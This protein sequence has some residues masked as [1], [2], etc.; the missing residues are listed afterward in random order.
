VP[1][2]SPNLDDLT[3]A[4]V[5]DALVR[6]IPTVAPEWT[7]HN[8]SDPGITLIQL[9]ASLAE[10]I[11]YRLN[12][13]PEKNYLEFLKLIGVKLRPAEAARTALA[14]ILTE[15]ETTE[16]FLMD[17]GARAKAKPPVAPG[18]PAPPPLVFETDSPLD[19][20]P[21]Q[22]AA[23][24]TTQS[25]DLR[26]L[27]VEANEPDA[28]VDAD[29]YVADL[30]SLVWDGKTPKLKDLPTQPLRL[31]AAGT[32]VDH[33]SLWLGLAFNPNR[34]TG[35]LASRVT[36]TVQM[37]DDEQ[38]ASTAQFTCGEAV[39]ELADPGNPDAPQV[40]YSYY[41]PRQPGEAK[42]SWRPLVSLSDTTD[43]WTR[44][45]QARFDIPLA[46]GAVPDDEWQDVRQPVVKTLKDL[47]AE[48]GSATA[49]KPPP[50]PIPHPLVGAIKAPV[51]NTPAAVPISGWIQVRFPG[52]VPQFSVR[53]VSFNVAPAT[54]A[55]TVEQELVCRGSGRP[56]QACTLAFG[57]VLPDTLSL[58]VED[59]VDGLLHDWTPAT[60][61]D[62]AAPDARVYTL[63][64]EAGQITFGDG[65][66]GLP[67]PVRMRVVAR[68]YRHGGG[69]GGDVDVGAVNIP[70]GLDSHVQAVVNVVA[71][72]GGKDA[73]LLE[74]AKLRAPTELATF[75]RAV[76]DA[77]FV[78]FALR[79]PGVRIKR[80]VV[81][82]LHIPFADPAASGP[83]LDFDTTV[84]GALSVVAVPDRPGLFPMPT[85]GELRQVCAELDGVRLVT[86]EVHAVAPQYV[87]IFDLQLTV[88]GQPGFSKTLLR[89]AIAAELVRYFHVLTGG[90]DGAGFPF[91]GVVHHADLVA[92]VTRVDGVAR[93]SAL[94]A[95][96]DGTVPS[97]D[98]G[99]AAPPS[100]PPDPAAGWRWER[101]IPMV[102]TGCVTDPNTETDHIQL[103][104]D[105]NVFIDAA[106][107][108]VT[109]ED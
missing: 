97:P 25:A 105:E 54:N 49:D 99:A 26:Q 82:P 27:R 89:E 57:N 70:D 75:G 63:D 106:G 3:Y 64:A 85:E 23:L 94:S 42:G 83:G 48:A 16:G 11:G 40:E 84:P 45:G 90:P 1:I 60:S 6:R 66:H 107:I 39:P 33:R 37:D 98:G 44:S 17:A 13:V 50:K 86:T 35:F 102:L 38:P 41:R 67:P 104:G 78:F 21:G 76:T 36:L 18:A 91:G 30:F 68:T 74:D 51:K 20:V 12:R 73:E 32:E 79:T 58:A 7:N 71:A 55:E 108:S 101:L 88:T 22:L 87:R 24:V 95:Q 92:R 65:R 96:C 80:A 5:R 81:V 56:G 100:D 77:D 34:N 4:K 52:P 19:V 59:P 15:P 61:F 53:M 62:A 103:R 29:A 9:F 93:V 8:D 14:F 2:V 46:M 43:G 28:T 72:R 10:Q 109:V 69:Q 47:C 31:F